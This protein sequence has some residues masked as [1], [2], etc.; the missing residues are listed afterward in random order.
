[1]RINPKAFILLLPGLFFA[2]GAFGSGLSFRVY[3]GLGYADGGDLGRSIAGWRDY[4]Q[5]R[6]GDGFSST[7]DLGE[8]HGTSEIGAE[9]VWSLSRRWSLSLG[10]GTIRQSARGD[11]TT[12]TTR[13]ENITIGSSEQWTVDFEQTTEQNPVYSKS[14]IPITLSLEYSLALDAK[15]TVTIGG[16]GGFYPSRLDLREAYDIQSESIREQQTGNG[17]VQ[18]IDRLTTAGDY[19]EKTKNTAFGLHGQIGLDFQLSSSAFLSITVLGRWVNMKGWKGTRRDASEWQWI[20]GLWGAN[21]AEGTDERTEDGQYWT[22]DLKDEKSGKSYP[23]V[24]FR[25]TELS[26]SSKPANFNL[27]GVS[28]RI[29]LGFRFGG[30]N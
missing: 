30:K 7:Y 19:S 20:Y 27:S 26:S 16:G 11:I 1:M 4:Y 8:M 12:R 13:Q 23:V 2:A 3:G 21:S 6:Q 5:S 24:M 14:T 9:A 10:V 28:I 29:G 25:D 18:Y 17:V 22:S 15:W